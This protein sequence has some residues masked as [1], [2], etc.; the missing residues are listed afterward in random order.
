MLNRVRRF[1]LVV[2]ASVWQGGFVFYAAVVVPA[3]TEL[4]GHF[5][6]GLVTQRVTQPLNLLGLLAHL[7]Y[8]WELLA[9][10]TP[11]RVRW[12]LWAASVTL[13]GGLAAVHV[14]MDTLIGPTAT[15]DGF[16]GWHI[17]Y[18]WLSTG[19]WAIAVAL[20]WLQIGQPRPSYQGL[21]VPPPPPPP[22]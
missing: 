8:L 9:T 18:L 14:Q 2:A 3:G 5:G 20:L 11:K 21:Q 16:R 4:H 19:Q 15:A 17:A 22:A 10:P 12:A 7:A 6:Q 13:L 1:V